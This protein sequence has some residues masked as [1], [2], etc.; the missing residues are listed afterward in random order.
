MHLEGEFGRGVVVFRQR[1]VR[2]NLEYGD[3]HV[4]KIIRHEHT[5][6]VIPRMQT[7][8]G[9]VELGVWSMWAR[10]AH[11]KRE[12]SMTAPSIYPCGMQRM[13][14]NQINVCDEETM[15]TF[16][17]CSL[18]SLQT[19]VDMQTA[20]MEVA[21]DDETNVID[22]AYVVC[23]EV[24]IDY[25][26]KEGER[27][28]EAKSSVAPQMQQLA[29]AIDEHRQILRASNI[30]VK[31][32]I[33]FRTETQLLAQTLC[34]TAIGR[35]DIKPVEGCL[36][37]MA[38]AGMAC[39]ARVYCSSASFY[40]GVAI[41]SQQEQQI[42]MLASY[43]SV[44]A[45]LRSED[46]HDFFMRSLLTMLLSGT[47]GIVKSLDL[48]AIVLK[49]GMKCAKCNSAVVHGDISTGQCHLCPISN[50]ILCKACTSSSSCE[51]C[52]KAS[53]TID[54]EKV[55]I[56][57]V[58]RSVVLLRK[59][60]RTEAMLQKHHVT[61]ARDATNIQEL[62]RKLDDKT[63]EAA[64]LRD[65]LATVRAE[66]RRKERRCKKS[67]TKESELRE[68][69]RVAHVEMESARAAQKTERRDTEHAV[70]QQQ[71]NASTIVTVMANALRE[72]ETYEK[73]DENAFVVDALRTELTDEKK[74]A[75][76]KDQMM[77]DLLRRLANEQTLNDAD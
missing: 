17:V 18:L 62:R 43:A 66:A 71:Q 31:R 35:S 28:S 30:D 8:D 49:P 52:V 2:E 10:S 23:I 40:S 75:R 57:N 4:M 60:S 65:E 11:E 15:Q 25:F 55:A 36:R 14:F 13:S 9:V 48:H 44:S 67:D 63:R 7:P 5:A 70:L 21:L 37:M 16:D 39:L 72:A 45:G 51:V 34:V 19:L 59:S 20:N 58:V 77:N 73:C 6:L 46:K 56:E 26:A 68:E 29:P 53:E 33:D 41:C 32:I 61:Q 54:F 76:V 22:I 42:R 38:M 1:P 74:K 12:R 3:K 47:F 64:M 69:L 27:A 50:V 24:A